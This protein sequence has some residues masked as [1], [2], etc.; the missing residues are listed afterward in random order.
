MFGIVEINGPK[1]AICPCNMRLGEIHD[2]GSVLRRL[3]GSM[4]S[5]TGGR[6]W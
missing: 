6:G 1:S 4:L 2:G 3:A 5:E